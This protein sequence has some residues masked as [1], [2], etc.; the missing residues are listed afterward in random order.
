MAIKPL[1]Q[2]ILS[3]NQENFA[4]GQI[5]WLRTEDRKKNGGSLFPDCRREMI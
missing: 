4:G 1:K 3:H 2:M 5:F